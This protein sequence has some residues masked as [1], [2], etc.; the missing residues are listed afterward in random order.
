[1]NN[2]SI[3]EP[4]V[5][6]IGRWVVILYDEQLHVGTVMDCIAGT[7]SPKRIRI[8]RGPKQGEVIQPCDY[9]FKNWLADEDIDP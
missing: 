7:D 5:N 1:M 8:Q 4:R 9:T 6:N 2:N 3:A